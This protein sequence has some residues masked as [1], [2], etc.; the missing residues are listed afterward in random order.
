MRRKAAFN[1]RW[2]FITS[3]N[4]GTLHLKNYY[5]FTLEIISEILTYE[6]LKLLQTFTFNRINS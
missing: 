1:W 2:A 6:I 4:Y 5:V 3:F